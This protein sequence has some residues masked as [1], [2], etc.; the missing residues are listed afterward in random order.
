MVKYKRQK[1]LEPVDHLIKEGFLQRLLA[2]GAPQKAVMRESQKSIGVTDLD[3]GLLRLGAA[4]VGM[5]AFGEESF[6]AKNIATLAARE[7]EMAKTGYT[8]TTYRRGD[9]YRQTELASENIDLIATKLA[10][11]SDLLQKA[12]N[13]AKTKIVDSADSLAKSVI[14]SGN[15]LRS[16]FKWVDNTAGRLEKAVKDAAG[17]NQKTVLD[18]LGQAGSQV[19]ADAGY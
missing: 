3:S 10:D 9:R 12:A 6:V 15:D 11:G 2:S 13:I 18:P 8:D 5:K 4:G 7:K 16:A 19:A 17:K 14:Y 1:Q